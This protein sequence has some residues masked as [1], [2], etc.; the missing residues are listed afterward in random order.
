MS[1]ANA[2]TT[3]FSSGLNT[4]GVPYDRNF[5][6]TH[7]PNNPLKPDLDCENFKKELSYVPVQSCLKNKNEGACKVVLQLIDEK[8]F[9]D[10]SFSETSTSAR[11]TFQVFPESR[12]TPDETNQIEADLRQRGIPDYK[13]MPTFSMQLKRDGLRNAQVEYASDSITLS[14]AKIPN[15]KIYEPEY[16]IQSPVIRTL[17]RDLACDLLQG[18]AIIHAETS[19]EVRTVPN[20]AGQKGDTYWNSYQRLYVLGLPKGST[21]ELQLAGLGARLG[22]EIEG[23]GAKLPDEQYETLASDLFTY[24]YEPSTLKPRFYK[25]SSKFNDLISP[26]VFQV[27]SVQLNLQV[28][29]VP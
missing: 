3:I 14:L 12:F 7:I 23:I 17:G 15:F 19:V 29:K 13:I 9:G 26:F 2:K 28:Q 27:P 5:E 1:Q 24:I 16:D 8:R 11:Q 20:L 10:L 18:K 6:L 21:R 4:V 25:D 22:R